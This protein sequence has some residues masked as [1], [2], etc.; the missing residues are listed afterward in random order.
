MLLACANVAFA[1]QNE[2]LAWNPSVFY[3]QQEN[4]LWDSLVH[5][6]HFSALTNTAFRA[7]CEQTAA[8][9]ALATPRP[10]LS[11]GKPKAKIVVNFI[12]GTDGHVH[13]PLILQSTDD[14]RDSIVLNAIRSWKF[15][16]ATCNG[17]PAEADGTVEFSRR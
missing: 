9:E 13:S 12:I 17:V 15:R 7:T 6:S 16:P 4:K 10:L 5:D 14:S 8:P 2:R 1:A 11:D 3:S